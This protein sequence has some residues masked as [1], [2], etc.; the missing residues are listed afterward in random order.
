MRRSGHLAASYSYFMTF[1]RDVEDTIRN[2]GTPL[3]MPVPAVGGKGALG[4]AIPD[5]AHLYAGDVTAAV[6]PCRHWVAEESPGLLLEQLIHGA[7]R[8]RA[9]PARG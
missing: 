6:H 7:R 1:H 4:Q 8:R 3:A 2:R 5:Q 9:S